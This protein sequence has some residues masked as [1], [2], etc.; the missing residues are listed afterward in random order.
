MIPDLLKAD[1]NYGTFQ[2]MNLITESD[3]YGGYR[4]TWTLGVTFEGVLSLNDSVNA[5]V[6]AQSGVTG[7]YTLYYD[8]VMRLP[9]HTVF[10]RMGN[11]AETY[12]V[13]SKDEHSTPSTT[14]L[15]MR[16]VHCEEYEVTIDE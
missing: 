11:P 7:L 16:V 3:G 15:D 4:R 2:T 6:A 10:C 5:Q 8:K 9:W 1:E 13:T 12:R 14:T